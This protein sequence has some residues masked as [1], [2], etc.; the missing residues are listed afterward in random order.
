MCFVQLF[1]LFQKLLLCLFLVALSTYNASGQL[2]TQAVLFLVIISGPVLLNVF[3]R[4]YRCD[5][6]NYLKAIFDV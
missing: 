2:V 3:Y 4:T 5:S 6:S 1:Q